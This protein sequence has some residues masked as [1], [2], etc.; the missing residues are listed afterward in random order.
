MALFAFGVLAQAAA[1]APPTISSV[2]VTAVTETTA[3]LKA[4]INPGGVSTTY[5]F[6]YGPTDCASSACTTAA[7]GSAGSGSSAVAKQAPLAELSPGTL[8]H[9]RVVVKN[10]AEP[11]GISS[12]DHVFAT[13]SA[14]FTGLPD[15]RAY[16]QASPVDKDG[17]DVMGD[18][19]TIKAAASG[20]GI[21]FAS[22]FGIPGGKGAQEFP[23]YL[24]SRG[25]SSW[26][27][28][29]LLPPPSAGD[30]AQVIGWSPDYTELFSQVSRLEAQKVTALVV[31]S[32]N[33]GEPTQITPYVPK[34]VYFYAGQSKDGSVVLFESRSK[35]LDEAIEGRTNLYAW[36]RE[37]KTLHLAGIYN[38][39]TSPPKGT[40]AGPYEWTEGINSQSLRI[41]GSFR[42]FYLRDESAVA[43]DG[44]IFFTE[45]GTGQ[46]YRRI[47][48]TK[49]Q[50][51]LNG[52]GKCSDPAKACTIHISA[53]HKTNGKGP[54]GNDSAGPQPAA[55]QAASADGKEVFF[56]S[57]EKLTNNANTGPEQPL[58]QIERDD[59][60]GGTVEKPDFISPQKAVG[61]AVDAG[62]VYWADPSKGLIGRS[63]LG[64]GNKNPSFL[65][66]GSV[67][68]EVEG[69]SPATFE[70]IP[71][72]PRY[73]AVD[74]KY[75]YW[76]NTGCSDE[77]GPLDHK[78]SIGRANIEGPVPTEI[79]PEFIKGASN[80]QGVAVNSE[81]I[82][83]AN[84]GKSSAGSGIGWANLAGGE[85]Q[86]SLFSTGIFAPLGIALSPVNV[87]FSLNQGGN[88]DFSFVSRIPLSGGEEEFLG[89]G[90]AGIRGVA[91]DG[92]H[93][94]WATQA[95]GEEAIG[96]IPL[97]DF[98]AG[99]FCVGIPSCEKSF[100]PLEGKP[101]GLAVDASHLFWATNGEAPTN[102]GNDL[103]R[104][105]PGEGQLEDLTPDVNG[106]G[107]EVQGL[108]GAS[109]DG[110]YLYFAANGVLAAG[111]K[112]GDCEGTVGEGRGSCNL[113]L[114]HEGAISFVARLK[115]GG[116]T[117]SD[118]LNWTGT[119]RGQFG[120]ATYF[121]KTSF[122]SADGRSLL[123]RSREKLSA[124]DNE[125]VPELYRFRVGEGISC[126]SCD[127]VGEAVG[128]GPRMGRILLPG[129]GLKT[130]VL[131]IS[132][133]NFSASGNQAYF[134]TPEAL[135]PED[136]NGQL[137]CPTSGTGVQRF[138]ACNDV[139]E[140]EAA[141]AGACNV[142]SAAYSPLNG[143][144]IYLLSSG[145][146]AFPSL[147]ADASADGK[148][149][150]FFTRQ[151]LV[152]QDKDELQ[153]V[154]DARADGGLAAQN[155]VSQIPCGS[156]EAC[157]GSA[158]ATP[159]Q[160]GPAT[161]TFVGPGNQV[162]KH[163]KQKAKKH[164]KKQKGKGK[165][166]AK[167]QGRANTNGRA[168]R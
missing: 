145:K 130:T 65:D 112:A 21:T 115:L 77:F 83:W 146:S 118:T 157:H 149:V 134:E 133:R 142:G 41:G 128:K 74:S 93:V 64:G 162:P 82:Y 107:A 56:T 152:G 67:E 46:L 30:R 35:L 6:E 161:P 19:P 148:D 69:S 127:P 48:P 138:P 22:T 72:T 24:A 97:S 28:Q 10:A 37:S 71:S 160:A 26:S 27:T 150:F 86:Q 131:A 92:S 52:E 85:V 99:G 32:I 165:S 11:A 55:F 91:V 108:L 2:K 84:G 121:P 49:V 40:L 88:S 51:P 70:E 66:P 20:G 143:G 154:Y 137:E 167:K 7:T 140:W 156:T 5:R 39:E 95:Q 3:I 151:G 12:G 106:N 136:T 98:P 126:V 62:H 141:G 113:Y 89:I 15:G 155:P 96:R 44:S 114:S 123:F 43:P 122:V 45:V 9:F 103:Y 105:G 144:C 78:G 61:V 29:G 116:G 90:K 18:L 87:Y 158:P 13:R 25:A 81:H 4:E 17:N 79:E 59:L 73:V 16:E 119:P 75:I 164:K 38:D 94:Y 80:P 33:G 117:D 135:V 34:A 120:T 153:D 100:I 54:N 76:T 109:G 104:Y 139:Y 8:Y 57:P 102:P 168:G 101:N 50:S 1:A 42:G 14:T 166:K 63:D 125:G 23:T 60:S 159:A 110:K 31:Q 147:F 58:A 36:D 47:N 53:S 68:C 129:L 163:K 111:A 124:Y 132:S